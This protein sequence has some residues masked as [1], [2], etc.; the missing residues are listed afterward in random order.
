ME[1][2]SQTRYKAFPSFAGDDKHLAKELASLARWLTSKLGSLENKFN[3]V[4]GRNVILSPR[5][6]KP[7]QQSFRK[8]NR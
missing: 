4:Q 3:F 1:S 7:V 5:S 2:F 6:L 8:I